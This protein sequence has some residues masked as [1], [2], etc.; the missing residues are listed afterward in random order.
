MANPHSA[1]ELEKYLNGV[2]YPAN[3]DNL[4]DTARANR[5]PEEVIDMIE[6]LPENN[7]NS[8]IDIAKA[9]GELR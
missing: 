5:A 3:K 9:F 6:N 4:L 7:F 8:P 1:A 2:V